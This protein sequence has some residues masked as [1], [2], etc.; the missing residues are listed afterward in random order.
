MAQRPQWATRL[1]VFITAAI[2]VVAVAPGSAAASTVSLYI[3]CNYK[4]QSDCFYPTV[5][6]AADWGETNDVRV[7]APSTDGTITVVDGSARLRAYGDA[8][9]MLD[10]H[11]ARC[12][13]KEWFAHDASMWRAEVYTRDLD[14]RATVD[15]EAVVDAGS[16]NDQ[17][18]ITQGL[19]WG[20]GGS[21]LLRSSNLPYRPG[22]PYVPDVTLEG[23]AGADHLVGGRGPDGLNGG[24]GSDDLEGRGGED[25]LNGSLGADRIDGGRGPDHLYG[26]PGRDRLDGGPGADFLYSRDASSDWLR[27]GGG[28]DGAVVDGLDRYAQCERV[29][30]RRI[31]RSR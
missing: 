17:V 30:V 24:T 13:S 19:V 20:R 29:R 9:L 27:C 2:I 31:R 10:E 7:G 25:S 21:D 4:G 15:P 5:T 3:Y 6:V 16:G 8:C 18:A 23:G 22:S 1:L 14:D 28:S 26:G 12:Q 11:T